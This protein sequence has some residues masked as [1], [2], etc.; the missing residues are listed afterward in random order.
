MAQFKIKVTVNEVSAGFRGEVFTFWKRSLRRSKVGV[1]GPLSHH[2]EFFQINDAGWCCLLLV[3]SHLVGC[4]S[5][6]KHM[7]V[8]YNNVII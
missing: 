7:N 5:N 3:G 6:Q 4:F 8:K 2:V 1:M